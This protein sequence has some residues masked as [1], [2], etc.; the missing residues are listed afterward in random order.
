ESA[1][2]GTPTVASAV[3]GLL[4]LVDHGH[5][6]YL[7]EGRDPGSFAAWVNAILEDP[8]LARRLSVSAAAMSRN[9]TWSTSAARLRRL[10]ED[11]T[12]AKLAPCP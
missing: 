3:G 11:L 10:Y 4:S 6:G 9:Y 2:C 12:Q 5:S 7:V 8:V 1:A